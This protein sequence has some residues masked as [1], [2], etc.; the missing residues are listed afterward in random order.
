MPSNQIVDSLYQDL[1]RDPIAAVACLYQRLGMQLDNEAAHAMA[2]FL[3]HKPQGKF[4]AHSYQ[5]GD[6]PE[7]ARERE[8]FRVYQTRYHVPNE[9]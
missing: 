3:K 7:L 8:Y 5:L 1:M 9:L 2:E 4:G 6:A